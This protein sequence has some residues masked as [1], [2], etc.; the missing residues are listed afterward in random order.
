MMQ[1]R[2]DRGFGAIAAIIVLVVLAVLAAFIASFSSLQ[3]LNAANDLLGS[4]AYWAAQAGLEFGI[5]R[6][7]TE[8][9][10]DTACPDPVVLTVDDFSVNVYCARNTYTEGETTVTVIYLKSTA[11][12]GSSVGSNGYVERVVTAM[13]E[14]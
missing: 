9:S 11:S 6:A 13:L 7:T 2:H 5:T 12:M 4:R 3:H 1:P 14:K 8:S 10:L